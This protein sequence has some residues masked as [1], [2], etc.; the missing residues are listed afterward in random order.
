MDSGQEK[1]GVQRAPWMKCEKPKGHDGPHDTGG[2]SDAATV[3][4]PD[5]A[6][7]LANEAIA[8]LRP[9]SPAY[10]VAIAMIAARELLQ[11][12]RQEET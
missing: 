8:F 12:P 5:R 9:G 1:C 10:E 4:E 6:A 11:S 7:R 2:S 3:S